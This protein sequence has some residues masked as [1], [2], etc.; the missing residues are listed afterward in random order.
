M[1]VSRVLVVKVV[2]VALMSF[3]NGAYEG[4]VRGG[5]NCLAPK[6]FDAFVD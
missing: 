5:L 2:A 6:L 1:I 4:Y 3:M